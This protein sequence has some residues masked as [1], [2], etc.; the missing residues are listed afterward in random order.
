M[1]VVILLVASL[2]A[3]IPIQQVDQLTSPVAFHAVYDPDGGYVQF[4]IGDL[5]PPKEYEIVADRSYVI[6]PSGTHHPVRVEPSREDI[7][8]HLDF[9]GDEIFILHSQKNQNPI[10]LYNGTWR[11]VLTWRSHDQEHQETFPLRV[12]TLFYNPFIQGW[13]SDGEERSR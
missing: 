12:W 2:Q 7:S 4:Y 3:C 8:R 6:D 5:A 13:P 9:V 10:K 11:F 1:L